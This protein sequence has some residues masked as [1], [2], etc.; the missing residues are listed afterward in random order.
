MAEEPFEL[1]GLLERLLR[2][3]PR[4]TKYS[5]S[6]D[7][8]QGC[9]G[10][11]DNIVRQ[12]ISAC[13]NGGEDAWI[14][15]NWV[16]KQTSDTFPS[17]ETAVTYCFDEIDKGD[18]GGFVHLCD[19]Q[20]QALQLA[21]LRAQ[22]KASDGMLRAENSRFAAMDS[23]SSGASSSLG[24][25]ASTPIST[26][27]RK[28]LDDSSEKG[29]VAKRKQFMKWDDYI[30]MNELGVP[31]VFK[32]TSNDPHAVSAA[33]DNAKDF[34]NGKVTATYPGVTYRPETGAIF[35][36]TNSKLTH[37][38]CL[39]SCHKCHTHESTKMHTDP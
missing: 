35:Q 4:I 30:L 36:Q 39:I 23:A 21:L 19:D 2:L 3:L 29:A 20:R 8:F 7:L 13:A 27:G 33:L 5:E 10:Q 31:F 17:L 18:K 16:N 22:E 34:L 9:V 28:K 12:L 24:N 26:G 1:Q 38:Q 25:T 6:T 15:H 14:V 11:R 37:C 32:P